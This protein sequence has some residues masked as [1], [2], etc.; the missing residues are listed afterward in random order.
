LYCVGYNYYGVLANGKNNSNF[1]IVEIDFFKNKEVKKISN[2]CYHVIVATK[3]E[4]YSWGDNRFVFFN[5]KI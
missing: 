5:F 4:V 1:K 3:E 2:G